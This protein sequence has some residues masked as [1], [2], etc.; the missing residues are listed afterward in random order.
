MKKAALLLTAA[1][2]ALAP[3]TARAAEPAAPAA[4]FTDA[5]R[6]EI[7]SIIKTYLEIGRA[8]V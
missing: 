8:H 1:F 6:A 5:Q 7:E 3:L 2:F 4:Q